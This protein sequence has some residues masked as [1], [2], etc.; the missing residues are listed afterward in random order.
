[1]NSNMGNRILFPLCSLAFLTGCAGPQETPTRSGHEA[2]QV[3]PPAT[4]DTEPDATA[5]TPDAPP[6]SPGLS[7]PLPDRVEAGTISRPELLAVLERGIPHFLRRVEVEAERPEGRFVGWR[8][9]QLFPQDPALLEASVLKPGDIVL[10]VNSHSIERPEQFKTVWDSL[11]GGS[12]IVF[13]IVRG[14]QPSRVRYLVSD[15][16]LGTTS[17]EPLPLEDKPQ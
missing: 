9:L 12:E 13:D 2:A 3:S 6:T 1:M 11:A 17:A 7:P 5:P 14:D 16:N 8:L 10:R 15:D 4:A